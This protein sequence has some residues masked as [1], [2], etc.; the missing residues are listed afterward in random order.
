MERTLYEKRAGSLLKKVLEE[1]G[2][3][4]AMG[5]DPYQ[6]Y[7]KKDGKLISEMPKTAYTLT[8]SRGRLCKKIHD[9]LNNQQPNH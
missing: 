5:N 6:T 7:S 1:Y 4:Q 3:E 8:T 9:F 2:W